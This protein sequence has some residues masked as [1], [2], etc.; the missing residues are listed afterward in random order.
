MSLD[1]ASTRDFDLRDVE[2]VIGYGDTGRESWHGEC[3]GIARLRDGRFVSWESYWGAT[4]S[5]FYDDSRG[6][7]ADIWFSQ[8]EASQVE[9]T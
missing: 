5:G 1:G 2:R 8:P 7:N 4:G 6:G 9:L 3:S